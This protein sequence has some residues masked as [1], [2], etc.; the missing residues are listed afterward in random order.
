MQQQ[1][2]QVERLKEG[3]SRKIPPHFDFSSVPGLSKE[4]QDKLKRVQPET[5]GHAS[6][7]PGVT[8]AAIAILDV[9]LSMPQ[10]AH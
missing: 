1:Q 3:E 4:V 10:V 8:P 6:R 9:Y 7:I 2:R 5:L